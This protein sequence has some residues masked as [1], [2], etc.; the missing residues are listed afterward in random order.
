MEP[1]MQNVRA[2]R[3]VS[4]GRSIARSVISLK[5]AIAMLA[6]G[7]VRDISISRRLRGDSSKF[8]FE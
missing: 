1:W 5:R 6:A 8:N 7:C 3:C 2:Y 4:L